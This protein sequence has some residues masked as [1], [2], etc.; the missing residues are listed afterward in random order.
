MLFT[1]RLLVAL[2]H[3]RTDLTHEAIGVIYQV[4]SSVIGRAIGEIRP[5]LAERGCAVP[6]RPGL[7][8]R[9]LGD[10]FAYAE[11]ENVTLRLDGTETQ[12]RRPKAGRAA[13]VS[14]KRKQN[15]IK[16]TVLRSP[17][18]LEPGWPGS[19]GCPSAAAR[20]CG[21]STRCLSRRHRPRG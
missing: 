2:V 4:W 17:A 3:L 21:C 18:G 10:V 14:G 19:S 8:L 20:C 6:Q 9:T 13:F 7:C 15:T 16:T 11:A 12:V 1:D 5:L